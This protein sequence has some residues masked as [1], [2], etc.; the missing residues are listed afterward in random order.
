MKK[1]SIM[2]LGWLGMPLAMALNARGYQ[3]V[4]SKTTLD[5]VEAARMSGVE[6]YQLNFT[7][8]MAMECDADDLD[9]L[10]N[11]DALIITLPARRTVEGSELYFQAVQML[12]DS[13]LAHGVG[14]I[15]FTSSTSVYGEG[16]GTVRE[17]SPLQPVTP[18][19]RVLKE[20]EE[21]FHRLP[22][23]SV[24]VLRLAGLVGADRHPGRFLAG[25]TDV[26]GANHG[27]NLVHQDDVIAAI[28]LLLSLPRGGHTFNLCAPAHPAKQ[29]F[30]PMLA[31]KLGLTEPTFAPEPQDSSGKLVDG[32]R[33]VKELGFDYLYPDPVRM[34]IN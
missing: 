16:M 4:G 9:V 20:L 22:N 23:T 33:I 25:K 19:G 24:D 1:V 11:V 26:K 17:D 32:S 5:G 30:Y 13:A 21:W 10:L 7:P 27:V 14:R 3:V 8:E 12:V 29:Q 34:P 28:V 15:I 6:C 31:R 2:G 18:S